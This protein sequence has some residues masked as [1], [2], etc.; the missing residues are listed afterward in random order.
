MDIG[1]ESDRLN[2]LRNRYPWAETFLIDEYKKI[3]SFARSNGYFMPVRF[4]VPKIVLSDE[5]VY[6]FYGELSDDEILKE[7]KKLRDSEGFGETSG[8]VKDYIND[9]INDIRNN[10]CNNNW[11]E[12]ND[13]WREENPEWRDR[14]P[15]NDNRPQNNEDENVPTWHPYNT[16]ETESPTDNKAIS[17]IGK[18]LSKRRVKSIL[19]G[20]YSLITNKIYLYI[21]QI[22]VMNS[23]TPGADIKSDLSQ[24]L[25]HEYFHAL[26]D[27]CCGNKLLWKRYN[28]EI[29]E[30]YADF[31]SYMWN[32]NNRYM[33]G[34][35]RLYI[36]WRKNYYSG[37]P[38]AKA[39][40]FL[41]SWDL[42][43]YTNRELINRW[44]EDQFTK[45]FWL[46]FSTLNAM[47]DKEVFRD[48]AEYKRVP[49]PAAI[50][51][52]YSVRFIK[53]MY[54]RPMHYSQARTYTYICNDL[55]IQ[56]GDIIKIEGG[57][58]HVTDSYI[59]SGSSLDPTIQYVILEK[60]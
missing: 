47:M 50:F 14:E 52:S 21:N 57:H 16:P 32:H 18:I 38:Y 25:A 45:R 20:R 4:E 8:R 15:R 34:V 26:H 6:G 31:F 27:H 58:V 2:N 7:L 60:V 1:Y 35:D 46:S 17:D 53:V 36:S 22:E 55:S 41:I 59:D 56:P 49:A 19:L 43:R 3:D 12:R 33:P 9:I 28:S 39:Y 11:P 30:G 48:F 13:N 42:Q 37:W 10:N 51:N 5:I 54:A 44:D 24:I 40:D 29:V 23:R